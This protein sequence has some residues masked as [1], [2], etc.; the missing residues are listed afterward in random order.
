MM[1]TRRFTAMLATL[2]AILPLWGGEAFCAAPPR[3]IV[4]LAP[5]ITEL[6]YALGVG[7]RVVGVTN[8]CDRPAEALKKPKVGGMTNP[9]LESILALKPDLVLMIKE[10][11][12]KEAADRL[13]KLGIRVHVFSAGRLA[14]LPPAI[15]EMGRALGVRGQAA[16]L[17]G[18]IES[19]T[20]DAARRRKGAKGRVRKALFIVSPAPLIVVGQGTI[21]DD[22]MALCGLKNIAADAGSAYPEIS[23]ESVIERQPDIIIIGSG[24]GMKIRAEALLKRLKTVT[25][26][27][28]GRVCYLG[29]ALYRPGPRIPEGMAELYN[30]ATIP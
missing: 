21:I 8:V 7:D 17:A 22:A 10:G 6:L 15:R 9:S 27:Q 23:L 14:D 24:R 5:A 29:D 11:N 13:K 1:K 12:P 2:L 25:A 30:C 18:K 20:S 28:N 4:S 19:A 26:V 16:A 3:R